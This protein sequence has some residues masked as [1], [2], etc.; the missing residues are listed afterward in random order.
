MTNRELRQNIADFLSEE[1]LLEQLIEESGELIQSASKR[2][3]ILRGENPTPVTEEK[4][5]SNLVEELA[6]ITTVA[7]VYEAKRDITSLEITEA[8]SDKLKRWATRL[9]LTD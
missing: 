7:Q 3:R 6:D 2:L 8:E 4:N 1:S 9:A 5:Y